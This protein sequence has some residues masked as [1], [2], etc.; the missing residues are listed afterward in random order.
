MVQLRQG[1][2]STNPNPYRA[3]YNTTPNPTDLYS[4]TKTANE[5]HIR[6]EHIRKFYTDDT[7]CFPVFSRNRNQYLMIVYHCDSNAIIV[8]PFKYFANKHRL[9]DYN[10]IM[11]WL[12]DRSML[13]DLQILD[14]EASA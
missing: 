7:A 3:K 1:V 5:L 13:V 6:V 11:Q 2:C 12:K 10:A 4:D 8:S 14:N 9:L